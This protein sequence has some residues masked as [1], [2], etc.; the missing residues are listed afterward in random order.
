M[1]EDSP[2][3]RIFI[4]WSPSDKYKFK[5]ELDYIQNADFEQGDTS[6]AFAPAQEGSME[7]REMAKLGWLQGRKPA[8][9]R[10][11]LRGTKFVWTKRKSGA[12]NKF[13]QNIQNLKPGKLYS[14]KLITGSYNSLTTKSSIKHTVYI[15]ID[16][17]E[18]LPD[19]SVQYIYTG[20]KNDNNEWCYFN[21][22]YRVFRANSSQSV[23]TISDWQNDFT[24]G[25]TA[26]KE[27]MF[28]FIELQPYLG[29]YM[30]ISTNL[31]NSSYIVPENFKIYQNYP[32]P[33]NPETTINFQL[34]KRSRV[35]VKI[36]NILGHEIRTLIDNEKEMG[37]HEIKWDGTNDRGVKMASGI[38]LY[39]IQA[40]NLSKTMKMLLMK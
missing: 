13:T 33:F 3:R 39:K 26:G 24:R 22:H 4:L 30:E 15:K 38:Y 37:L 25:G 8:P 23:L 32:N 6:W 5:Y 28:N 19:K 2:S 35:A 40:E 20:N 11:S 9:V 17:V 34:P 21:Y 16:D 18:M 10:R 31:S 27:L 7:I 29:E 36:Y 1:T 14:L 12:P